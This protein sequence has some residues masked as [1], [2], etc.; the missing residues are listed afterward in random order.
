MGSLDERYSNARFMAVVSSSICARGRGRNGTADQQLEGGLD[1][2]KHAAVAGVHRNAM[3]SAAG[4]SLRSNHG[5]SLKVSEEFEAVLDRF[6]FPLVEHFADAG[7]KQGL[8]NRDAA[9]VR[10][11]GRFAQ[12]GAERISAAKAIAGT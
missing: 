3:E 4:R 5:A 10:R 12:G 11:R 2:D 7:A 1:E 8:F 9:G 6:T